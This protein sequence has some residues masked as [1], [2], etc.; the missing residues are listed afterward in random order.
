MWF[1][2]A[3]VPGDL[4]C[5]DVVVSKPDLSGAQ[6]HVVRAECTRCAVYL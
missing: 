1:S 4:L 2:D 5:S 6:V 3:V